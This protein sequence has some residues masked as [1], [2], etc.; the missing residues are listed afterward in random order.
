MTFYRIAA[1]S[2]LSASVA[3]AQNIVGRDGRVFTTS[4]RISSGDDVRIY[5]SNGR[6]TITQASGTS[7]EF[8]AEKD[9]GSADDIGFVVLRGSNGITICAI[10]DEDDEC[11]SS[12]IRRERSNR[13]SRWNRWNDRARPIITAS[14]PRDVRLFASSGNG[15]VSVDVAAREATVT[16][17]NGRVHVAQV[18]GEVN[19]SSGNGHVTVENVQGPVSASS[20]NGDVIVGTVMGPVKATTGNGSVRASMTRL[21]AGD[22]VFTSGNGSINLEVPS[23]FSADLDASTGS[24]GISTD[25][26]IRVEGRLQR[27]R[28]RGTIGDGGRSLRVRTGNGSVNIRKVSR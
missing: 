24:G 21:G 4:E 12:G 16:S 28:L 6:I 11:T 19:A 18:N 23:D 9:G 17:G 26:P 7:M 27:N 1:L 22:M 3:S 13:S 5:S 2:L 25:F 15:D 10:Y 20:G 8:R 14:V